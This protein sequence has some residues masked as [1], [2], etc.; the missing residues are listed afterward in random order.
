[1]M[2]SQMATRTCVA[3]VLVS[4]AM[5]RKCG[6]EKTY[7]YDG[8][9]DGFEYAGNGR[10]DGVDAAADG[11]NDGALLCVNSTRCYTLEELRRR[12]TMIS[13]CVWR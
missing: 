9:D 10:D 13:L 6:G 2:K 1:M 4:P 5:G 3:N 7:P 12:R 11:R 8:G